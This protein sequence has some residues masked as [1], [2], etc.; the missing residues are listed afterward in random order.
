MSPARRRIRVAPF[1]IALGSIIGVS[2]FHQQISDQISYWSYEPS[3]EISQLVDKSGMSQ[4]GRFYFFVAHPRLES[5]AE[6][7]D[8]CRR[9]ESSS[10]VVGCFDGGTD[11]IHIYNIGNDEIN[12]I[13]E[14][15]A[16]HEML[17]VVFSRMSPGEQRKLAGQLEDAYQRLKT[18]ALEERML[19]Y[20]RTGADRVNELHS[21]I[22]TEFTELGDS[23][24]SYYDKYF[25]SRKKVVQ[26]HDSYSEAFTRIENEA[27]NL[28]RDLNVQREVI[29]QKKAIYDQ[30]V[31]NANSAI[32]AF[33]AR[34]RNGD[35]TT[36]DQFQNE[37]SVV[38]SHQLEVQ[39]IRDEM[40]DLIDQYNLGVERLQEIGVRMDRINQSIDSLKGVEE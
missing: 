3:S 29:E 2:L 19:Q 28:S 35:F 23:L 15:T 5:A 18:P 8:D 25:D 24:E 12:G 21:I 13:K 40:N 33:N 16:A 22:P 37:R 39:R 26:L 36:D 6:F 30:G 1:V 9:E 27:N 34:A 4:A 17:H 31:A 38:V 32:S 7:N 14:V 10:P 20:D 11:R